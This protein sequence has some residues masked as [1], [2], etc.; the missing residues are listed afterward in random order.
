M[1]AS[2]VKWGVLAD[3][4]DRIVPS[5]VA[6][7]AAASWSPGPHSDRCGAASVVL[8]A[9]VSMHPMEAFGRSG[10]KGQSRTKPH[11]ARRA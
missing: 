7:A 4:P 1:R 9:M 10:Q 3:A 8:T 11:I 6:A 2:A 5:S